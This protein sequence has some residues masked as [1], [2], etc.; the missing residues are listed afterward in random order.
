MTRSLGTGRH[1]EIRT[2]VPHT[3][4]SSGSRFELNS[5][6]C[7]SCMTRAQQIS[8]LSLTIA[9]T[10]NSIPASRIT[11]S[12]FS[13][14]TTCCIT[15]RSTWKTPCLRQSRCFSLASRMFSLLHPQSQRYRHR[16]CSPSSS[17]SSI[18]WKTTR[19]ISFSHATFECGAVSDK[20]RKR[21]GTFRIPSVTRPMNSLTATMGSPLS[22]TAIP[23][24]QENKNFC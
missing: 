16:L 3:S 8:T 21:T 19:S 1:L 12:L 20:R 14:L 2:I 17:I 11:T 5:E 24:V 13:T 10:T 9:K 6:G 7:S 15:S 18:T 23:T 22:A 4:T